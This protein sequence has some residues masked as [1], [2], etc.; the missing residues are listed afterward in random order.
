[1]YKSMLLMLFPIAFASQG[2]SFIDHSQIDISQ[3]IN[4]NKK[5]STA[6]YQHALA[7]SDV[8]HVNAGQ[9]VLIRKQQLHYGIPIYGHSIV[10]NVSA[11]GFVQAVHGQVVTG[12]ENDIGS[13]LPMFNARQA[14][15]I[16]KGKSRGVAS[17]P[18]RAANAELL[19][20]LDAQ[21]T[22]RLIYKVDYVQIKG[23]SPSRPISLVD[24]KSGEIIEQWNGMAFIQAEGPGGN[25]KV[26]AI[27][28]VKILNMEDLK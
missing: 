25:Q 9:Q 6:N 2:A 4:T 26:G 20:W 24:A 16:V 23:K 14:I 11:K 19:I 8:S 1:M 3:A 13:L 28:L 22:A 12:I 17:T 10:T 15:D 5:Q 27:I 7:Y 18:I 21:Q